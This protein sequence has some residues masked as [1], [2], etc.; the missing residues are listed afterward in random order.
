M[1]NRND[2]E[3]DAE[4]LSVHPRGLDALWCFRREITLPIDA[5]DSVALTPKSDLKRGIRTLGT[6]V[7]FKICG[8]FRSQGDVNFW[9]YRGPGPVLAIRLRPGLE[10]THLYLSVDHPEGLRDRIAAAL[11]GASDAE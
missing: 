10:F 11:T 8:T 5:V 7:G 9:N 3:V 2:V 6:D 1:P 4:H